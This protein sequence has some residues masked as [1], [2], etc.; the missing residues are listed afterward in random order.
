MTGVDAIAVLVTADA[1][2]ADVAINP[3]TVDT[4]IQIFTELRIRRTVPNQDRSE[5]EVR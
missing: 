3:T 4:A 1:T 2:T 5:T